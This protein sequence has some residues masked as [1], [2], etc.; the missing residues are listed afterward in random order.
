MCRALGVKWHIKDD[1]FF[2][3]ACA[4]LNVGQGATCRDMSRFVTSMYDLSEI[5]SPW[6]VAGKLLFQEATCLNLRWNELVP[7]SLA[8]QWNTWVESLGGLQGIY[9]L[10][11]VCDATGICWRLHRIPHLC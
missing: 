10:S 3:E 9:Y 2:F 5:V 8:Q 4:T 7:V 11:K 1:V 6:V